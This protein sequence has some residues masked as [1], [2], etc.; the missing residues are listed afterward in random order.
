MTARQTDTEAL[1]LRT[2]WAK[3]G[4]GEWKVVKAE[5]VAD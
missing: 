5:P 4:S 2:T 1:L 3:S